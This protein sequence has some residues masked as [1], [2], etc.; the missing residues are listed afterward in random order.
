MLSLDTISTLGAIMVACICEGDI[1][2]IAL[3]HKPVM[4]TENFSFASVLTKMNIVSLER[5]ADASLVFISEQLRIAKCL[6]NS[7]PNGV[8]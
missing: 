4:M 7:I 2:S 3:K 6:S 5:V 8:F 1:K